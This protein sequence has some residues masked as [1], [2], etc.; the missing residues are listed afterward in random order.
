MGDYPHLREIAVLPCLPRGLSVEDS[1]LEATSPSFG[2]QY[3]LPNETMARTLAFL[4]V[5]KRRFIDLVIERCGI[6]L[7]S[8]KPQGAAQG[9]FRYRGE[10]AARWRALR[11]P[12]NPRQPALLDDDELVEIFDNACSGGQL[13]V[14]GYVGSDFCLFRDMRA[15]KLTGRFQ[16]GIIDYIWGSGHSVTFDGA[17]TVDLRQ[18]QIG[19][20]PG[21]PF[22]EVCSFAVEY[23]RFASVA[24]AEL[25]RGRRF[26]AERVTSLA[27]AA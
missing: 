10:Y 8:A 9:A 24:A 26:V 14:A 16:I 6:N 19:N 17:L 13:A 21:C 4:N 18:G 20:A 11:V 5:S 2:L 12:H 7:L 1:R 23:F 3:V 27:R 22:D 25:P 15:V